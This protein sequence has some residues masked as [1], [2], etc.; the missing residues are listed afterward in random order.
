[1][2]TH[3]NEFT[4]DVEAFLAT[5]VDLRHLLVFVPW[6]HEMAEPTVKKSNAILEKRGAP[7]NSFGPATGSSVINI[8]HDGQYTT[9]APAGKRI[10]KG[11]DVP[12]M[13][14]EVEGRVI[15]SLLCVLHETW[16]MY[17]KK[18]YGKMLFRL[19]DGVSL[20]SRDAF[21]KREPKWREYNNTANYFADYAQF[22]CRSDC[23]EALKACRNELNWELVHVRTWPATGIPWM[24]TARVLA[25]CRHCIVHNEG[26]VSEARLTRLNKQLREYVQTMMKSTILNDDQRILPDAKAVDRLV[27]AMSSLAYGLYVLASK[28]FGLKIEYELWK[29]STTKPSKRGRG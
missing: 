10:T 15:A 25:F 6:L 24:D 7:P 19:R 20:P 9:R 27:E 22:A 21:H 11:K 29:T 8:L 28:R 14:A 26:R 3:R 1:M 13:A 17:V 2:A 12:R 4:G 16:E 18:L 5:G 23:K